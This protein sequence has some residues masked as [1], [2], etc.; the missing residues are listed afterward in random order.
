MYSHSC[1]LR[2]YN[3]EHAHQTQKSLPPVAMLPVSLE[4]NSQLSAVPLEDVRRDPQ[5]H[6]DSLSSLSIESEDDTNLLSQV[7][8]FIGNTL[9]VVIRI[10]NKNEIRVIVIMIPA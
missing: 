9:D 4:E 10:I 3:E 8:H 7:R 5:W 2:S 1:F 6:D